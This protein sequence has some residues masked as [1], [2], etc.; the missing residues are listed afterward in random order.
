MT[1]GKYACI[2]WDL[3]GGGAGSEEDLGEDVV[4]GEFAG[5]DVL[6]SV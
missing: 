4:F 5:M 3:K 6:G 2:D 1:W